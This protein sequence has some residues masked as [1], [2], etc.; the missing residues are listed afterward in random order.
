MALN[1]AKCFNRGKWFTE[2]LASW[3]ISWKKDRTIPEGKQ[4][5]FQR[6]KSWFADEGVELAVWE[7]LLGAG[8]SK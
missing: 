5:C 4:G 2:K 1:V 3:E 7:H 6:I 8:E